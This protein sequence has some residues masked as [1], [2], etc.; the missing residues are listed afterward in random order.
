MLRHMDGGMIE[1]SILGP[2]LVLADS[3][4]VSITS[5]LQRALLVRL[6]LEPGKVVSVDRLVEDL[7]GD[8]Q[9]ANPA[10]ALRYHVWQLRDALEP[11]RPRRSEGGY[12]R[13]RAPGY[14]L[15]QEQASIDAV[16]FERLAVAGRAMVEDEP[17]RAAELLED[18]LGLWRGE[19][20][21]D[22]ADC[23]FA[24]DV[25]LRLEER[26]LLAVEDRVA[27]R[28]ACGAATDLVPELE[29]L[30]GKHPWRERLRG[31][32]MVALYRS[33]RQADA[34]A[35]FRDARRLFG[36][37][38][39]IEPSP[40]LAAIEERVLLHD[41]E[42]A[43]PLGTGRPGSNLP[44]PL[45][46]FIGR[47]SELTQLQRLL[48]ERRLVT[49]VG[50]PGVGK[51]RLGIQAARRMT[52]G[53]RHVAT[54]IDLVPIRSR[55][56]L[57]QAIADALELSRP[58][59]QAGG[60][61][62]PM[63]EVSVLESLR[64]RPRL[65]VLDNCE[66]V[67]D[68]VRDVAGAL[69]AA[70]SGTRI[71]A[72]SRRPLNEAAEVI[73]EVTPLHVIDPVDLGDDGWRRLLA[74]ESG[75]LFMERASDAG[76][77]FTK[78]RASAAQIAELCQ[79]LDGLPLALE[80]AAT[81]AR[82]IGPADLLSHLG[83]RFELLNGSPA[84]PSGKGT[85][86][87]ALEWSYDLLEADEAT[88]LCWLSVF[89]G[90]FDLEAGTALIGAAGDTPASRYSLVS[91]LV[92]HSLL[93]A[94]PA[95][96]GKRRF[97]LLDSVRDFALE[98]VK[99]RGET[100]AAESAHTRYVA[101]LAEQAWGA[102]ADREL[103]EE[104]HQRL[105]SVRFDVRA[106]IDRLLASGDACRAIG[107][108]GALGEYWR[109]R[110]SYG[111]AIAICRAIGEDCLGGDVR[112][113][114]RFLNGWAEAEAVMM[115]P[116][117]AQDLWRR[118][119]PLAESAGEWS[120][121][122]AALV[123]TTM[124]PGLHSPWEPR[125]D[126]VWM[127]A[128]DCYRRADDVL[129]EARAYNER[130][131]RELVAGDFDQASTH[132]ESARA[133]FEQAEDDDGVLEALGDLAMTARN[134]GDLATARATVERGLAVITDRPD[135]ARRP[136]LLVESA[137]I[138]MEEGKPD[139]A[140]NHLLLALAIEDECAPGTFFAN[141]LRCLL[142]W[143]LRACGRH[144]DALDHMTSAIRFCIRSPWADPD[145]SGHAAWLL[146]SVAGLCAEAFAPALAATLFG[147]AEAG[148]RR[149]G[150]RMPAWDRS[151]YDADVARLRKR[152]KPNE[153]ESAWEKGA[154]LSVETAAHLA[155]SELTPFLAVSG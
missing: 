92:D 11:D 116:Q 50:S 38:L 22:V 76:A 87:S 20:L 36:E 34:L 130:G 94:E 104:L 19:A 93:V 140:V 66:H 81:R 9:P 111:D 70:S 132:L 40:E 102:R 105:D 67:V 86:W 88:A 146:E 147:A 101:R 12:V 62:T 21:A 18:A 49:L 30:A 89:V 112:L 148:R 42:L 14:Y 59:A 5:P 103:R 10:N 82:S 108:A 26:R 73:F 35:A 138:A 84:D 51:T 71:L 122:A 124:W 131:F 41:T 13:T 143:A 56:D 48:G 128:V 28:L 152:L 25:R 65:L 46:S 24:H 16:E 125:F 53:E 2:L 144:R 68:L 90:A 153:L 45:T 91:Q 37:E 106:V 15:D 121:A 95:E 7:W 6:L 72:T 134:A 150:A 126:G 133:L 69:L 4:E 83:E 32:L 47:D 79:R 151:R 139:A 97:R 135:D 52:H 1:F 113:V 155:I 77:R 54:W 119:Y 149:V 129:G 23:E 60:D 8:A 99:Q 154:R 142:G 27:A 85:L 63:T 57:I 141:T 29:Q 3:V 78:T 43:A 145:K 110:R 44:E 98:K 31:Q 74:T 117:K 127:R 118:A 58:A 17:E 55:D 114:A 109:A 107:V 80:L 136:R 61:A 120:L 33:G 64:R 137:E 75:A 123:G 39:G 115:Q 100:S 96:G